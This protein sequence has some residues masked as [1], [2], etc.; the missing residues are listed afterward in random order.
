[1]TAHP[2]PEPAATRFIDNLM[3]ANPDPSGHAGGFLADL[4]RFV[5]RTA[6]A[7]GPASPALGRVAAAVSV[8]QLGMRLV[9]AGGRLLRRHP[10]GSLLVLAGLLGALYL[11]RAPSR[12]RWG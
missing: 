2:A 10:A 1:M 12:P 4:G 8:V 6:H 11:T 7:I 5:E 9:P 3:S